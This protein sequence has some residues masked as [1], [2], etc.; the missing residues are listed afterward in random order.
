MRNRAQSLVGICEIYWLAAVLE[1]PSVVPAAVSWRTFPRFRWKVAQTQ[2][3]GYEFSNGLFA[4]SGCFRIAPGQLAIPTRRDRHNARATRCS[5]PP[6]ILLG[7]GPENTDPLPQRDQLFNPDMMTKTDLASVAAPV[8]QRLLSL[9]ALRGFDMFWIVGAEELVRG[10]QKIT[11]SG[12]IGLVAEQLRHQP[13]AGFHFE[14]LIFPLFV[15]IVGVS[16]VFSLTK[17][18]EQ[19]GRRAAVVRILRRSA[20][21]YVLGILSYGG[22][23]T[24]F[25]KIRLLGVLQRMALCY[26]FASLL[27]CYLKPKALVGVCVGLL[28]GYWALLSFVPV[29]GH[30]AGNF[31]EGAN[32]A[33]YVDAQYLPLRK[34][35]G[36]HDPEGLLSTLPAIAS[37]LL[38]VFAGLLLKNPAVPDRKKV[39]WLIAAGLAGL[40]VGWLWHLNFPVIK[41]I[42]TSS[43]VLVAGGYSCLLLAA[44]YQIIDV[45][46]FQKWATPFVWIGVNPITI[47]LGGH[48]ID[49]EAVAKLFVGGPVQAACGR[50]GELLLAV[51]TLAF[52]FLFLRFL[53]QRKIFLRV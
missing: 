35:D 31:A 32:L 53:Y 3:R 45:W 2:V 15:F 23:S 42:W 47:Y 7:H 46:K 5:P 13:W 48:F 39:G 52:G 25:E 21:L 8:T 44:F 9:D 6:R 34:W 18:L 49:F 11:A 26:L 12:P 29:P 50:Y 51:T 28:L 16:L 22:L 30:G 38:G 27:F 20:L 40:A 43:F 4:H 1:I 41:K 24:P 37:C 33:N 10:L 36:D 14:D 17:T 19:S